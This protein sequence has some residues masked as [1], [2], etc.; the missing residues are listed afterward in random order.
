[1]FGGQR[2]Q[3][4]DGEKIIKLIHRHWFNILEHFLLA[5]VVIIV[6]GGLFFSFPYLFPEQLQDPDIY[7]FFLFI[8]S[9]FAIFIWLYLFFIWIDYYFDIWIITDKRIVNIEQKGLFMRDVSELQYEK[10]QDVTTEVDGII[11][12]LLNYGDVSIQT[13]GKEEHFLFRQVP[14]PYGIKNQIMNL[15]KEK[16]KEETDE[17][18]EM[19]KE[20]VQ[21][22]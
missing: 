17:L 18:G 13:A 14:D 4:D 21:G 7:A 12:T 16:E 15:Q 1:M 8:E 6:L 10:I 20:K 22:V 3:N 2:F 5:F 9:T 19:I 11:P